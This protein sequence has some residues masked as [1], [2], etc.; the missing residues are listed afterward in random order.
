MSAVALPVI[1]ETASCLVL[2]GIHVS[3]YMCVVGKVR[4]NLTCRE[5]YVLCKNRE[6]SLIVLIVTFGY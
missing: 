3:M 4:C 6:R 1:C 5:G 2:Y